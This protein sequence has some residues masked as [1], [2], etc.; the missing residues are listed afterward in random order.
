MSTATTASRGENAASAAAAR[1]KR[2]KSNARL[3][4]ATNRYA[5]RLVSR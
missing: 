1:T 4:I 2:T 3:V 5:Q